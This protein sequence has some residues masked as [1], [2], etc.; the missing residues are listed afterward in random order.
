MTDIDKLRTA[1]EALYGASWQSDLAR[2]LGV[3]VRTMQR[4]A[5]SESAV[6][7]GVWADIAKLCRSRG[8]ALQKI[9]APLER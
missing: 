3:S 4:W 8:K 7:S 5:A 9:A 2:A 6:P 1:G